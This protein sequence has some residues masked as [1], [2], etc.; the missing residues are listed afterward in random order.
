[1]AANL[2]S[3][4]FAAAAINNIRVDNPL[5]TFIVGV[6]CMGQ[7]IKSCHK[8]ISRGGDGQPNSTYQKA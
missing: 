8:K 1:M 3:P 7:L 2:Y 4:L 5:L 6:E